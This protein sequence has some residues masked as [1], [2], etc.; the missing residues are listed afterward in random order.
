MTFCDI[1]DLNENIMIEKAKT[2]IVFRYFAII[3]TAKMRWNQSIC[4]FLKPSSLQ[5]QTKSHKKVAN[6]IESAISLSPFL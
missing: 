2:N 5:Q 3:G 1:L 6:E 4:G